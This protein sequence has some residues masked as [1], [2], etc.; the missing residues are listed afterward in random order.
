MSYYESSHR[1]LMLK[2]SDSGRKATLGYI[3]PFL[4]FVGIM[5]VERVIPLPPAWLYAIRFFVVLILIC[6][7]SRPYLSP[8]ASYPAASIGIGIA[9]F[10]V[11]VAPDVLF[12][13][14]HHWLFENSLIP[15][16]TSTLPPWLKGNLKFIVLR[17]ISSTLLIPVIEELFWRGWMLRWLIDTDFLRV[18]LGKYVPSAFWI[19]ALLFAFEHGPYWEVGLVAGIIYNWWIIRTGNLADCIL[20]H[21]V[22]NGILAAY[23]LVTGQWQY[24]L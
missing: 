5:A 16:A 17:T 13:Y 1:L 20:A 9:V 12:G 24:W 19:V 18:P 10:I 6:V 23:V 22:T 21:G 2:A 3:A 8:R 7:L 4:A 11:W 15:S 14:R